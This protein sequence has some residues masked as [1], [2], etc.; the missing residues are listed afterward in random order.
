[1]QLASDG[2]LRAALLAIGELLTDA[3]DRPQPE[4][5]AA[6]DL[7]ADQLVVLVLVA[8]PLAVPDDAPAR[9]VGDHRRRDLAR[10]RAERFGVD[11]LYADGNTGVGKRARHGLE[12]HERRTDDAGHA[13]DVRGRGDVVCEERRVE[14]RRVHLPVRTDDHRSHAPSPRCSTVVSSS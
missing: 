5:G 9:Q 2:L 4:L 10:V 8:P 1:L 6:Q 3:Q 13:G 11:V 12:R 14:W 7:P